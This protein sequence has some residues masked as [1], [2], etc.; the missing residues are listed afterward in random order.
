[1]KGENQT[2][3]TE[4][5]IVGFYDFPHLLVPLFLSFLLIYILV[6]LGN[7]LIM[8][9]VYSNKQ[10]HTPMFFFLTNLAF[11]DISYT[12]M[13]FPNMLAHFFLE[14]THISLNG[15]LLM[16]M[17]STEFFLLPVMAYDR[18]VA[19]C[20][21]LQYV[22]IMNDVVC[23]KLAAGCWLLSLIDPILHIV[24]TSRLSFC[25]SHTIN[26]FFCDVVV[27][28]TLSC[29]S[30]GDIEAASYVV[31]TLVGVAPFALTITSYINIISTILK[32]R[33]TEGRSKA[34]STCASH[35]TVVILFYGVICSTYMRPS[36][37]ASVKYNKV[38]SL[39]YV[40]LT[41]LCN[42]IIY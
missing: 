9:I 27:V 31:G 37:T 7:L 29:S 13:I 36:S 8:V 15:C 14:V 42:P 25:G 6:L 26:H 40:A 32:I 19:I 10:L 4:F 5:I 34:F 39:L 20:N 3:A 1:M 35:L 24:L 41:P 12:T 2:S 11:L 21:P 17:V 30:T 22:T 33:S 28:M 16:F 38:L 18:Y 23:L